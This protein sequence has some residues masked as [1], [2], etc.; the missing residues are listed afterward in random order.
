MEIQIED[1][2]DKLKHNSE[3]LD[4]RYKAII[5]ICDEMEKTI[6]ELQYDIHELEEELK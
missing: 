4:N 3:K 5:D 6:Q 2:F 1:L